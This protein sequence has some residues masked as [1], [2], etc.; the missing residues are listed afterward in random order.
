VGTF[1]VGER[2]QV[3][4]LIY[5]A[6]DSQW[7]VSLGQGDAPRIPKNGRFLIVYLSIVNGGGT[8]DQNVPTLS[9]MDDQGELHAELDNGEGVPNWIGVDRKIRSA[10]SIQ[11]NVVFD[12]EPKHYKLKVT[13]EGD[14]KFGWIDLPLDFGTPPPS[15]DQPGPRIPGP[16]PKR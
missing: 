10:E 6:M 3:G 9:L 2:T 4:P 15:A 16:T 1:K 14:E 13:E 11:G 7:N 8:S 12:V 5:N